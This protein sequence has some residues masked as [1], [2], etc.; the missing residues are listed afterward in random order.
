MEPMDIWGSPHRPTSLRG[1]DEA[2]V[3]SGPTHS[4]P[5]AWQ[6]SPQVW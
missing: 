6:F 4:V 5:A 1:M 3:D 2:W